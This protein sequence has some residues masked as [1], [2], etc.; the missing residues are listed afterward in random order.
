MKALSIRQPWAW[1]IVNGFKDIEN[2]RWNT[3][4]RGK[5]LIHASSQLTKMEYQTAVELIFSIKPDI[6]L[7]SF[8]ELQRGGIIGIATITGTCESSPSPWF[9]GP[10][11]F[12]L[13]DGQPLPFY[14]MRGRLSFFDTNLS[15]GKYGLLV[16]EVKS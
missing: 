7:P 10:V 1:L 9:F 2:R 13:R 12:Q 8:E 16:P 6:F 14:P 15:M 11:G 3:K 5:V 4:Y